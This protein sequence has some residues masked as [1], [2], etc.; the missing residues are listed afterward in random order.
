[1]SKYPGL[2][3]S[4][5]GQPRW[6]ASPRL[7]R[8]G[9]TSNVALKTKDGEWMSEGQ[10]VD[11]CIAINNMIAQFDA[12]LSIH[13]S[14]WAHI[15]PEGMR[16]KPSAESERSIGYL[17]DQF[18]GVPE[19]GKPPEKW[20]RPPAKAY[21][22]L[23]PDARTDYRNRLKRLVDALCGYALLVP[24]NLEPGERAQA[25]REY[26]DAVAIARAEDIDSLLTDD[27]ELQAAYDALAEQIN[28]KT[29]QLQISNA[30][31]VLA[32]ASAWLSWVSKQKKNERF[33]I[34]YNP[35]RSVEKLVSEGRIRPWPFAEFTRVCRKAEAMGW[36]SVSEAAQ[37]A[38]ETS[39][40]QIDV[41]SMTYGAFVTHTVHDDD[42]QPYEQL[43]VDR[44][45]SKTEVRTLTAM[46][47]EGVDLYNRI[48]ARWHGRFGKNVEPLPSTPLFTVDD[49]PGQ[50]DRGAVG[51]PWD[52][53]YFQ[54]TFIKVKKACT[55]PI[56]G[57][58]FQDLR[59]TG[60][61]DGKTA[62]LDDH[63]QQSRTQHASTQS[64]QR[65]GAKHYGAVDPE[66]SAKAARKMDKMRA[67]R[68][69]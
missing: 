64:V 7:R 19:D 60:F 33:I 17:I 6:K 4:R 49:I 11:A 22:K 20:S 58:T 38:R 44:A 68:G 53:T 52:S 43:F 15:A 31:K 48:K 8:L 51:K 30:N 40:S 39:W 67:R 10:A 37:M 26:H 18:V 27:N 54:H 1:M 50:L 23:G 63:E 69:Y 5:A 55:P 56:T 3:L 66:V 46:T 21:L 2:D 28:P 9:F 35:A 41:L 24:E 59:D 45:R 13:K 29:G 57:Y 32:V 62:G 47:S 61:T 12:G 16:Q 65:M 25:M 34:P 36:W 42:G 14:I